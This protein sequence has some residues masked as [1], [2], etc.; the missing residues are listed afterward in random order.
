MEAMCDPFEADVT[1]RILEA[2]GLVM[3][4]DSHTKPY[5][6][7]DMKKAMRLSADRAMQFLANE[8]S[9]A[10]VSISYMEQAT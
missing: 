8:R 6:P 4:F 1:A 3:K 10:G 2:F 9:A 7:I 5:V